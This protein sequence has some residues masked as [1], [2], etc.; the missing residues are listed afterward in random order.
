MKSVKRD[1]ESFIH[2]GGLQAHGHS[3]PALGHPARKDPLKLR[4]NG[5]PAINL[6][7]RHGPSFL[8]GGG[9]GHALHDRTWVVVDADGDDFSVGDMEVL[10]KRNHSKDRVDFEHRGTGFVVGGEAHDFDA[11][12]D[13][14][15]VRQSFLKGS[16]A[17]ITTERTFE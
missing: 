8:L 13:P 5:A 16:K 7:G 17:V 3:G 12:H 4:L 14:K 11:L 1:A 2:M 10:E 9:L 15:E 6:T